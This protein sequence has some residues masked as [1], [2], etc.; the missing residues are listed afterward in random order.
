MEQT[1]G[2]I[3]ATNSTSGN[4]ALT[5]TANPLT[6]IGIS[7]TGGTVTVI[8]WCN[9]DTGTISAAGGNA[10]NLTSTG[11][12]G[13]ITESGGLIS[14]TG[15]LTTNSVTGQTLNG[16]NTIGSN[17]ST[18]STSGNIA[19]TNTANPLTIIGISEKGGT[20][21]TVSNAG[22][23]SDTGK[24]SAA[25]GNAINLTSTGASGSIT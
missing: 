8:M 21:R 23:I 22:A 18:N 11:A 16:S 4:I 13:S 24:I 12:S 10:I 3:N 6:I 9:F 17:Y 19:L 7:E 1:I 2:S 20:V 14:T 5:N 15:L 25:G